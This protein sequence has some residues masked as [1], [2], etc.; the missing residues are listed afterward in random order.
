MQSHFDESKHWVIENFSVR[1]PC[2]SFLPGIAGTHGIP[3]WAFYVNRGQ[4]IASFGVESKDRAIVEYQPANKAYAQVALNGFRT[5]LKIRRGDA[6]TYAEPFAPAR[7]A[8][9]QTMR[10]APNELELREEWNGVRATVA[11]FI[12]P[13][14]NFAALVRQVTLENI[15]TETLTGEMLDG[16]PS[17]VPFGLSDTLLKNMSRT[18]EAWMD[19]FNREQRIP[20]YRVR[21][22]LDDA[23]QV[24]TI[25]AGNFYLAFIEN[26]DQ[27]LTP[28]ADPAIVFGQNTTRTQPDE[29][30]RAPL[31][32]LLARPQQT[33]N[34][35]PCGFFGVPFALAPGHR[36]TL[37]AVVGQTRRVEIIN[38]AAPRLMQPG[39]LEA[40]RAEANALVQTLTDAVA[41]HTALPLFDAY[42]RQTYLDNVLR[43]GVPQ[44]FGDTVYHIYSRKHGDLERD[45]NA[46]YVAAEPYSQGNGNYRDTNQNRRDDV[47]FNP[48][49][50]DLNIRAF[51][52]LVQTD[53]YNP[54]I[55]QGNRFLLREPARIHAPAALADFFTREFTPGQ[56][57]KFI[58]DHA[59]VLDTNADEFLARVLAASESY[60]AA[61]HGEGYWVDHWTYNLDLLEAYLAIY[62]DRRDALWLDATYTFY[63]SAVHVQPR[64]EKYVLVNGTPR[65]LNALTYD[66]EHAAR[67]AARADAPNVVRAAHGHGE[68]FRT[69]LLGKL[70]ALAAI[71]FATL[72]PWGMGIEMEAGKPGW[73]DALNGLPG[74]FGSSFPETC[75]LVRLLRLVRDTFVRAETR[76]LDL[77]IEVAE[78]IAQIN[79]ALERYHHATDAARDFALW[80]A[81][82]TA[83]ETYRAQTRLGLDGRTTSLSF[84]DLARMGNAWLAKLD[85]GMARALEFNQGLPPTYFVFNV[86]AFETQMDDL[87]CARRD[88]NGYPLVRAQKFSMRALPLF[89]EGV[90]RYLKIVPD[91]ETAR[92]LYARVRASNLFDPALKTYKVNASLAAEP[93]EIGRA[94]AFT[95]GWLENESIWMHMTFKY[96]LAMFQAG[97]VDEYY[98]DLQNILPPFLD[99][100]IYGRS[101]LENSSFIVSSAHPDPGLHGRGFVARLSGS[102]AEF[103]DLWNRMFAGARPFVW[104]EGILSLELKPTLPG[105]WFDCTGQVTFQFLTHTTVTYHN[106]AR[107][108][109][110]GAHAATPG[111]LV[112]TFDDGR[113]VK[114]ADGVLR[115]AD[116]ALVRAGRAQTLELFFDEDKA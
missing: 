97:L 105:A 53:G 20:F 106:P 90:V 29:F 98:A 54:L 14:E 99:P 24:E 52:N 57:L 83:R 58:A 42:C 55:V 9:A 116:V 27:L 33:A 63:A 3:L 38:A 62:P 67:I 86:A 94:R 114:C 89:L 35:T 87:G 73:Y 31:A 13:N 2:A 28:I 39:Y 96:L 64:A 104:R 84:V 103:L 4:A 5:F 77:P 85:A 1:P 46:F 100:E 51:I 16:L 102:T 48:R 15:S 68:I 79:A 80:D 91:R 60:F 71:K 41:T 93:P 40:K 43:G 109:T 108:D 65:Q 11:Y 75:E 47:R 6:V 78:L 56:L 44:F 30:L 76:A 111:L 17:I 66:V 22:S 70:V 19:V 95:P 26:S 59:I 82:A 88:A 7:M 81:L 10:I 107:A 69:T 45:Y 101:L 36:L 49:V 61:T 8:R 113:V 18:A 12:L 110:F 23:P 112:A 50:G 115:G 72:D 92:D 21:A 37:R 34:Q 25:A 32:E 74:M